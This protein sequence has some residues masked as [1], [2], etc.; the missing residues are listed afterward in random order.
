M[1]RKEQERCEG[2]GDIQRET[3]EMNKEEVIMAQ[4]EPDERA[5]M[6]EADGAPLPNEQVSLMRNAK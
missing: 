5:V 6:A 4:R 2:R 1:E 3:E